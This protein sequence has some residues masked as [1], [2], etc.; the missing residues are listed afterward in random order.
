MSR[1]PCTAS[2]AGPLT[3]AIVV[4]EAVEDGRR[5]NPMMLMETALH[6]YPRSSP[7]RHPMV[8]IRL[9]AENV[10][11]CR[12]SPTPTQDAPQRLVAAD[13]TAGALAG[14]HHTSHEKRDDLRTRSGP[15]QDA[16]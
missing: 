13:A 7:N 1:F 14:R 9:F 8:T 5:L 6:A 15:N 3:P 11:L 12:T 4:Y 2:P 10:R 16:S